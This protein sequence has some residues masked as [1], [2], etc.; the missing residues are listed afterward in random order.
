MRGS[1]SIDTSAAERY[2]GVRAVHVVTAWRARR[3][4]AVGAAALPTVRYAGASIAA[5]AATTRS[6]ADAAI[7]LIKVTYEVLP[8][9]V[10][11]DAARRRGAPECS[12]AMAM[13]TQATGASHA[14]NVRG[15]TTR[16]LSAA[17]VA[18]SRKA[19]ATLKWWS[20]ASFARRCRRIVALSRMRSLPIGSR[21]ADRLHLHPGHC[22][23]AQ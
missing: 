17:R 21:T 3:A 19:F 2:P 1:V 4:G 14:A 18:M 6:A 20:R 22:W 9:V 15:P 5:V 11:M 8:F 16:A 13:R 10:D 7:R 12:R 23:C